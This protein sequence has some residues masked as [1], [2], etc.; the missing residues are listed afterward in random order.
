MTRVRSIATRAAVAL[1]ALILRG[2]PPVFRQ[3]CGGPMLETFE[4]LCRS[5]HGMRSLGRECLAEYIDAVKGTWRSRRVSRPTT[6]R[7]EAHGGAGAFAAFRQDGI[8]AFRRLRA[9]PALVMLTVLTLGFAMAAATAVFSVVNAVL[10]SPSPFVDAGRLMN[11]VNRSPQGH[12]YAGLSRTKLRVWRAETEIFESVEAYRQTSVVVTGGVEPEE[13]PAAAMSPALVATL[14]VVPRNGRLF[15]PAEAQPGQN[16]VVLL[17]EHYWRTRLGADTA[18]VGRDLIVNGR[19][20]TVIGIMPARF[21]FPTLREELWLPL[22]PDARPAEDESVANTLVRLRRGLTPAEARQ[23]IDATVA[24]LEQ[25]QPLPT[26][27]AIVLDPGTLAGPDDRT[28]RAVM[29]LFGAVVL[30]LLTASANVANVLLSRAVERRREFAIR[31]ALGAGRVRLVRELLLEGALLGVGAGVTGLLVAKWSLEALVG[32]APDSLMYATAHPPSIDSRVLM[33]GMTLAVITGV[34]CNVPP[35]MRR[36]HAQGSEVLSG[37]TRTLA[38]TPLQRRLRSSLVIAELSLAVVLLVGAGLMVRSFVKLNSVDV[39]F[40]PER[41]LAVTVGLDG[42]RYA[43][44]ASRISL[45][46]RVARD[47][48]QLPHVESVAIASGLPPYPGT[49]GLMTPATDAGRCG[50]ELVPVVANLVSPSYFEVM[51][52]AVAEGRTLR[53]D[54]PPDTVVISSTIARMCGGSLVGRP[55]RLDAGAPWLQVIGVAADVRTRGVLN[56]EGD[57]AIYLPFESDPN[58][59]PMVA[60]LHERRVVPRRL[61]I[62]SAQPMRV[63]DAVKRVLWTHEPD[64]P[65][66]QAAPASDLLKQSLGRERFVLAL[67]AAFSAVALALASAGIFGVLA[68]S[69]A[70]RTNEIG[71]RVA[72]GASSREVTRMIVGQGLTLAVAGIAVGLCGAYALSRLLAGLLYEIDPRD[73]AVFVA[74]PV[75]VLTVAILAAWLPAS[76]ALAVDPASALRV[77]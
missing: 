4:T 36:I 29:I 19:P 21:H 24:R 31:L 75:L 18:A 64:Q 57:A 38:A 16:T 55:L 32:L 50:P 74:I 47:V 73:P 33:F 51:G 63:L 72:L 20:H 37:R 66:L 48:E 3:R 71:I 49:L 28:R 40:D 15:I 11:L 41:V 77:E 7:D 45:L 10:L 67:M 62:R 14:G 70:Q 52:V 13:L 60:G 34:I 76:R 59:L 56:D 1:Y 12:T 58:V 27:W 26:G 42:R 65:I 2:Y 8:Y 23:R 46:R 6:S 69:V 61:A 43:T 54:D 53:G 68:Y 17:S 22:D 5:Q 35:A 30:V 44:E 39:G 9:Q 25:E